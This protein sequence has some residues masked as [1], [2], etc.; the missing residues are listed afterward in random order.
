MFWL[1][2]VY[3]F[4]IQ[5]AYTDNNFVNEGVGSS[6]EHNKQTAAVFAKLRRSK[7]PLMV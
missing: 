7:R 5:C 1:L 4:I 6:T 2:L 3:L